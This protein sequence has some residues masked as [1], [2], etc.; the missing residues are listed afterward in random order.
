MLAALGR[1]RGPLPGRIVV[2]DDRPAPAG[3]LALG[4][5]P[6]PLR[7]LIEVQAGEG[8]GPAAARNAGWRRARSRWIAFLD[9]DVLP[10]PGWRQAL[11]RDIDALPDRAVGS[12]GRIRVPLPTERKPTDWERNTAGLE[13]ARWATAD[14]AYRRDVLSALG[15]F[16]ER[17][18]RAYREDA[19]LALRVLDAGWEIAEGKRT[20]VHPVR[21]A[22][23]LVSVALQ[24]GNGDDVL[25]RALRER[26]LRPGGCA[27]TWLRR[28]RAP[29]LPWR[30]PP[31]A[32]PSPQRR[33][34]APGSPVRA[35]SR[36]I[37]SHPVRA[38]RRRSRRCLGPRR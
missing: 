37:A 27:A 23:R 33:C 20:T 15:G 21:P 24:A 28:S 18:P 34:W 26:T 30:W 35:S 13:R 17:F 6:E 9:D 2:V 25:M 22:P 36:G 1:G 11:A 14:M 4:D 5:P 32:L 8:R 19:D 38:T 3:P 7:E 31:A 16:D 10:E 29:P 12:Q